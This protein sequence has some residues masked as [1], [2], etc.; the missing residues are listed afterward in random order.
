MR[1]HILRHLNGD[2]NNSTH[3]EAGSRLYYVIH[4]ALAYPFMI[5]DNALKFDNPE[6]V[7]T[8]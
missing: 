3:L 4:N 8:R 6:N 2:L 7:K 1:L 5:S